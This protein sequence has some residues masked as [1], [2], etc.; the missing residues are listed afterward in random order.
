MEELIGQATRQTRK[1]PEFKL[2]ILIYNFI[3][4]YILRMNDPKDFILYFDGSYSDSEEKKK[5]QPNITTPDDIRRRKQREADTRRGKTTFCS[6]C[7]YL[8]SRTYYRYHL[9]SKFHL[10]NAEALPPIKI[11]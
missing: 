8:Y 7:H 10:L 3:T 5:E 9:M 2:Q 6:I 1:L 4:I 11:E